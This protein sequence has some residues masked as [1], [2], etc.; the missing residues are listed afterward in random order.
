RGTLTGRSTRGAGAVCFVTSENVVAEKDGCHKSWCL[1]N[2]F[3][4]LNHS[5]QRFENAATGN[6]LRRPVHPIEQLILQPGCGL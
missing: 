3:R 4:E 6:T 2:L 1:L 5:P